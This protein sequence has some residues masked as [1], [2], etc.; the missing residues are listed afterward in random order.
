MMATRL[1]LNSFPNDVKLSAI[2]ELIKQQKD[3][4]DAIE[5]TKKKNEDKHAQLSEK[6]LVFQRAMQSTETLR[7]IG[8]QMIAQ[9]T[10]WLEQLNSE[11]SI[12]E[13]DQPLVSSLIP[14]TTDFIEGWKAVQ[15][16][17]EAF[18]SILKDHATKIHGRINSVLEQLDNA[19]TLRDE[20]AHTLTGLSTMIETSQSIIKAK[21]QG[22]LHPLRR[23]PSEILL[24]IF[25]E[26]MEDEA[27]ELR[28]VLL[29]APGLPHMAITLASVCRSWRRTVL[30]SPRLWSYIRLPVYKQVYNPQ[31]GN[32]TWKYVGNDYLTN[33]ASRARAVALELTVPGQ[34]QTTEA[35]LTKMNIHRLNIANAGGTWPPPSGI[36]SPAHLWLGYNST[37]SITRAIPPALVCRTARITCLNV[38]PEFEAPAKSVTS[39]SLQGQFPTPALALAALLG[40][41]PG[42]KTLDLAN[43]IITGAPSSATQELRHPRLLSLAIHASALVTLE[44]FLSNGLK[45][46]SIR[47][48]S[49]CGLADMNTSSFNFP[50]TSS[51]L[52]TSVTEL[53]FRQGSSRHCIRSWID[54]ISTVDTVFA[55]GED[56]KDT[57]LALYFES[58][59]RKGSRHSMPKGVKTLVIREYKLD[60]MAILQH[61]QDL[62]EHPEPDT[63]V[64]KIVFDGCANIARNVREALSRF[65]D[66]SFTDAPV[67]V[68]GTGLNGETFQGF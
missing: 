67:G 13:R 64:I 68:S 61:L 48:F 4:L 52:S 40:N 57:L 1:L 46:S 16:A 30:L 20:T 23:L 3:L 49:L 38:Y 11:I 54:A 12:Q 28:R 42:L 44:Q 37:P 24:Q 2:N 14:S 27:E 62:R 34:T 66:F 59:K 65:S 60:G 56:V 21:H 5:T 63:G 58:R 47:H 39:L 43:L 26:C 10:D 41:L 19:E 29:T 8:V 51:Q 22:I 35:E 50:F 32:Y 45:L 9:I 55:R 33:F 53:E 15:K 36:S 18:S 31:W 6:A 7:E 17:A 25:G